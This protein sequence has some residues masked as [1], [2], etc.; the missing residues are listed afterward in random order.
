MLLGRLHGVAT[1]A[2]ELLQQLATEMAESGARPGTVD[3]D[4]LIGMFED[5]R[6]GGSTS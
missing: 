3:A 1:P 5:R 6:K 2:N 4:A